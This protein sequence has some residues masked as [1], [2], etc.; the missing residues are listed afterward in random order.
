MIRFTIA[1]F[2][3][4]GL[5]ALPG[6]A[7]EPKTRNPF[8][9]ADVPDPDGKDVQDF[10]RTVKL[11]GD[12]KDRNAEQWATEGADGKKGSL[13]GTWDSRWDSGAGSDWTSGTAKIK[14]VGNRVYIL[15]KDQGDYL[16]DAKRVGKSLLVGRYINLSLKADSTPWV[17]EIVND[18]R[19]D[20]IWTFPGRWD[21]RR[22]LPAA[23]E[24]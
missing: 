19:I 5:L 6:G 7:D 22:K 11:K 20:G 13:D 24:K 21:M 2:M 8:N 23:K 10:A 17:G 14:T 15:Y 9:V 3:G 18:E 1:L 4:C 12:D 16:I